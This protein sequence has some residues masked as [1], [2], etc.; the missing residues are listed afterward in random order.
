MSPAACDRSTEPMQTAFEQSLFRVE[1]VL[2]AGAIVVALTVHVLRRLQRSRPDLHIGRA[3]AVGGAIRVLTA[4]VL[5]AVAP[6]ARGT[7]EETFLDGARALLDLPLTSPESV[8]ALTSTLHVWLF[9]L[10]LRIP[11]FPEFAMR[12]FQVGFSVLGLIFLAAAVH[13]LAGPRAARVAAWATVLEPSSIFFSSFLH[14]EPFMVFGAGIVAFG[15]VKFWHGRHAV[16]MGVMTLGAGV[17]TLARPY[18]GAMLFVATAAIALHGSISRKRPAQ[19][20]SLVAATIILV[21][22]A[23]ATPAALKQISNERLETKLQTVH[24]ANAMTESNLKLDRVDFSTRTKIITGL[25]ARMLDVALRPY[26]WQLGSANQRLGL[27]GTLAAIAVL[28]L[29]LKEL[30]LAR[31]A[32]FRWAGPILYPAALL[33]VAFSVISGNAGTSF[34]LR[35]TVMAL[36]IAVVV[37]IRFQREEKRAQEHAPSGQPAIAARRGG[38]GRP[39]RTPVPI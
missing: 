24:D 27:P 20:R 35:S 1:S 13:D 28:L 37:V 7:D 19:R 31:G 22:L 14:K 36:A 39:P 8:Q 9:S 15:G 25:P 23:A 30:V 16:G 12:I 17:A 4:A 29:L 6:A 33:F 3:M 26:P 10:Q 38:A 11:D 5:S 2:L 18:A 32:A 21:L 34:R